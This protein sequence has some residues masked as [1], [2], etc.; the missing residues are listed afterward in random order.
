MK[1][2]NKDFDIDFSPMSDETMSLM[3][4]SYSISTSRMMP[5]RSPVRKCWVRVLWTMLHH[6]LR[7]FGLGI[8]CCHS[9]AHVEEEQQ[10]GN[11]TLSGGVLS[12]AG[13]VYSV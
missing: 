6:I 1:E 11:F 8:F 5:K 13:V 2:Y 9:P 3:T 4:G 7:P 10:T 12:L